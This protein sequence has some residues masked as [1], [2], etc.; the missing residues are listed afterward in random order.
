MAWIEKNPYSWSNPIAR[1]LH[2]RLLDTFIE[3]LEVRTLVK[4][5]GK[6]D[7]STIMF[8]T[9]IRQVWADTLE[10]ATQQGGLGALLNFIATKSSAPEDL[11]QFIKELL[12][13]ESPATT[14]IV[15]G[16]GQLQPAVAAITQPEALLYKHDLSEAIGDV[17]PLVDA[18]GRVMAWRSSVCHLSVRGSTGLTYSGT[19]TLL[20]NGRILTNRHVTYPD[21][22]KATA[23]DVAFHYELD[24][25]REVVKADL[26]DAHDGGTDDWATFAL[27]GAP[28]ATATPF[29]LA[30]HAVAKAGERAFI[31]QHPR[32]REKRLAFVR[33]QISDVE[34]RLIHY[35]TDTESGSSGSPVFNTQGKLIGIHRAGGDPQRF[36]GVPPVKNNEGVRIDAVVAAILT[37]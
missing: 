30:N 3:P 18:V 21:G 24:M 1:D 19:G 13:D 34:A 35:I 12:N 23:I 14:P 22:S 10:R 20:T 16:G 31:I 5:A 36:A 17:Q 29:D 25:K 37:P 7:A 32:G 11:N 15:G 26:S 27:A 9:N 8:N 28:P 6:P 4:S 33:N 2:Q